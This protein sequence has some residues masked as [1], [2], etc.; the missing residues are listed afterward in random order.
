MQPAAYLRD[1]LRDLDAPTFKVDTTSAKPGDLANPK[2]AVGAK[3]HKRPVVGP[4]A[5]CQPGDTLEETR[6][7]RGT[8]R[9]RR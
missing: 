9:G 1:D 2:T 7:M 3:R 4:G 6:R 8:G 5:V